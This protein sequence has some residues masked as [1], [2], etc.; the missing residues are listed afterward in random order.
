VL[1]VSGTQYP[2]AETVT[3][4]YAITFAGTG[5]A[6]LTAPSAMTYAIYAVDSTGCTNQSPVCTIQDFF[7]MDETTTDPNASI[8][9]AKQ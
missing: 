8:I 5:T 6:T 4:T 3:G 2:G 7:M 9:F 1:N